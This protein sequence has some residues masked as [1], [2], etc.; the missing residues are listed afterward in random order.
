MAQLTPA[1]AELQKR[2]TKYE[3]ITRDNPKDIEYW[4]ILGTVYQEAN[5]WDK[6]LEADKMALKLFP[7]YA[8]AYFGMGKSY[9]GKKDYPQAIKQFTKTIDLWEAG[10]GIEEFLTF[11]QPKEEYIFSYRSRGIAQANLKNYKEAIQDLGISIQLDKTNPQWYKER[12]YI[13]E[14]AQNTDNAIADYFYAG[15]I[16][17]DSYSYK[18]VEDCIAVLKNLKADSKAAGLEK[19]MEA[20]K[21]PKNDFDH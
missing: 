9:F 13:Y 8:I 5:Q 15:K 17:I 12:A 2:I 4:H 16:Y 19:L 20:K 18:D 1:E 11:R 7:T 21:K 14:K 3:E 10:K 6:A